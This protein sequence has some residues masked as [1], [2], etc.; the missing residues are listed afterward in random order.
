M[1]F[2]YYLICMFKHVITL[3]LMQYIFNVISKLFFCLSNGLKILEIFFSTSWLLM[4]L[5]QKCF[6][7]I[8]S[9]PWSI[10]IVRRLLHTFC[11][12]FISF[13]LGIFFLIHFSVKIFRDCLLQESVDPI[14]YE[15]HN[16]RCKIIDFIRKREF[17]YFGFY[18]IVNKCDFC[19]WN[20]PKK[21]E[22]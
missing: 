1:L 8:V 19:V 2:W 14:V 13:N 10:I 22:Q 16:I 3:H 17:L 15:V 5:R 12:Y 6:L 7:M 4:I 20:V 11:S 9:I 18:F 21:I